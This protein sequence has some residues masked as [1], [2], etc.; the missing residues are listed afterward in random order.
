MMIDDNLDFNLCVSDSH[1]RLIRVHIN[2]VCCWQGRLIQV[3][4]Y[5][6]EGT[7]STS[8]VLCIHRKSCLAAL[9][10]DP[11]NRA[12][13]AEASSRIQV[14]FGVV[15]GFSYELKQSDMWPQDILI[16]LEN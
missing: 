4:I 3:H 9:L 11:W 1:G 2:R 15:V 16:Y 13:T 7:R 5:R 6:V 12:T 8:K 10:L 14:G